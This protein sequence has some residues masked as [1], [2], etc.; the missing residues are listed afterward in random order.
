M[1]T[2]EGHNAHKLE[3]IHVILQQLMFTDYLIWER[4]KRKEVITYEVR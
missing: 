3:V 2:F 4:K 1:L